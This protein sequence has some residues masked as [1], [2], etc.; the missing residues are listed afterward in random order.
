M[1]EVEK[2]LKVGAQLTQSSLYTFIDA[3]VQID[4]KQQ[5][6]NECKNFTLHMT[7]SEDFSHFCCCSF[8][9]HYNIS[10]TESVSVSTF[11]WNPKAISSFWFFIF[12]LAVYATQMPIESTSNI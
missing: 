7:W 6:M 3:R 10:T 1:R 11:I 5:Q 4:K 12:S 9:S 2:K 8:S